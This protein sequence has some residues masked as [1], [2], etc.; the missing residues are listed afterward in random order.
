[1]TRDEKVRILHTFKAIALARLQLKD[2]KE[3]TKYEDGLIEELITDLNLGVMNGNNVDKGMA[4]V[5]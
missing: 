1:M 4:G 3:Y 2:F 5:G